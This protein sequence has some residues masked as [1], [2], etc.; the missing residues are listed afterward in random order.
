M[1]FKTI[2]TLLLIAI[3]INVHAINNW[4]K[5]YMAD[6]FGDTDYSRPVYQLMVD[7]VGGYGATVTFNYIQGVFIMEFTDAYTILDDIKSI[8]VK[9]ASGKVIDLDF[10]QIRREPAMY[11]IPIES[12]EILYAL[13]DEGDFTISVKTPVPFSYGETH[14]HVFKI[15]SEGKG[16][17]DLVGP[18]AL[19]SILSHE[20]QG[21]PDTYRGTIGNYKITM[22]L[23]A[24]ASS[25]SDP[26]VFPVL[27]VY[28]YGN[29]SNGKMTLKGTLTYKAGGVYKLDEYD[30]NGKKC[31]SFVLNENSD[32]QTYIT[33]LVGKMTNAKGQTFNVNLTQQ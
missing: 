5:Q 31:G 4:Q 18:I 11:G 14:N 23:H 19:P 8:K 10:E 1:K 22:Q 15:R 7:P 27:G 26:D 6:E 17:M 32:V 16:L 9:T 30:P 21:D 3:S 20:G 2:I 13:L 33:T 28:W 24:S 29:G 25:P 12:S